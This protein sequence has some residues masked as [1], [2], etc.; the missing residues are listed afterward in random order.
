MVLKAGKSRSKDLA[1]GEVCFPYRAEDI[2]W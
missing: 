2:T 1:F